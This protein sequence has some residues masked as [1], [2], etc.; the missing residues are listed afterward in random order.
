MKKL[1]TILFSLA[2]S[3][4]LMAQESISVKV[5]NLVSVDEQFNVTF[6]IESEDS[7]SDFQWSAGDDFQLVWGPQKGSS[8]SI[9]IVNGTRTKSSQTTYTY[10]LMPKRAGT[11][12][13]RSATATIKGRS[14]SSREASVEVVQSSS[15][16]PASSGS[17]SSP[18]AGAVSSASSSDLYLKL[19]LS[20]NS[21]IVGETISA[22]LKLYQRVNIAGFEDARFPSFNGFWSQE[23]LSPSNI[24]FRREN[25]GNEIYNTAVLRSWNLIP[26]QAGDI[27]I[28]PAELVC[29]VN[30]RAPHA[31]TGSIFDSFFQDDY[32]T[33]RKRV[34]TPAL[35]VHVSRL[36]SGAPSSFTG[37]VGQ[38]KMSVALS[39]DSLATH[40]A[41]SLKVTV[42][43]NG[44]TSLL[45]A[46]KVN[47]PPDFEVY[48]VKSTDVSGGKV[49]EYPFIPRS[50]GEFEM[51]P[52][53]FSYF[54]IKSR[55]YLTLSGEAIRI[56]VNKGADNT[57][58][59]S[60]TL[61]PRV[62]GDLRKDVK[63]LGSD[64]RYIKTSNEGFERIG[65]FF[66][67]STAFWMVAALLAIVF[68]V[69]YFVLGRLAAQKADV[70]LSRRKGATKMARKRL[71]RAGEY[72]KENLYSA[73]YEELHK[74]L[75]G[76]VSDKL[77]MDFSD[78]TKENIAVR[79]EEK[80]VSGENSKDFI[81]LLDACEYARYAPSEGHEAMSAHFEAALQVISS[82]D[83]SMKRKLSIGSVVGTAVVSLL[84]F[85]P[86]SACGADYSVADSLWNAGVEAFEQGL[87]QEAARNWEGVMS[88]GLE[89]SELYC[90]TA[91]AWYKEG[92]LSRAVLFYE[93][94]LKVDPSNADARFNLEY[95]QHQLQD[96][97][98]SVPEFFLETWGRK[99]CWILPSDA[100]AVL[101]LVFLA[102]L[103]ACLLL[104]LLSRRKPL[105]KTGFGCALAAFVICLLCLDFSTWQKRDFDAK[106]S[107]IVMRGVTPVKSSPS[108]QSATDL[109]IL[110]EGTKV[111]IK[112]IVGQWNNIILADGRQ[113]WV[114]GSDLEVI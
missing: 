18:Q 60:S 54:D 85:L 86:V 96:R 65:Q 1:L 47:F 95:V 56:V 13:L 38:F 41:A 111:K 23:T 91:D 51:E 39:R 98:E 72:L 14:I 36:P 66:V 21:A 20:K 112:D 43:G 34:S 26:Q 93:R 67:F 83:D 75:L 57:P 105:R 82:I 81:S 73:F 22:T 89:S 3:L 12:T 106:D 42:T 28:D 103:F 15:A 109:F 77:G 62:Q 35:T 71:S 32:Q 11:F 48:D 102:A 101:F 104:F 100:W 46:P 84:L 78:M 99:M 7:P 10:V 9:S 40:E 63:D 74:A 27:R 70:S 80:G 97:I 30:V 4:S 69:L 6:I 50:H 52:V 94:A 110:H 59:Q 113:G 90:N 87:W 64:I 88:V 16:Q 44:N 29:L 68:A 45:E 25:V 79:L 53:K 19:I 114:K 2:A 33:V 31:S 5:Q 49:F 107:A 108:G 58:G 8:T 76:Y 17:S 24:E 55:S 61:T 92:V 37:A